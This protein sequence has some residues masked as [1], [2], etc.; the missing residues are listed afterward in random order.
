MFLTLTKY[1][2]RNIVMVV[3]ENTKKY[4]LVYIVHGSILGSIKASSQERKVVMFIAKLYH[5]ML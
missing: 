2:I 3:R 4:V 1:F 5:F